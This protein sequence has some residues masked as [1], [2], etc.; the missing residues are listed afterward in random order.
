[1]TKLIA[2][3]LLQDTVHILTKLRNRL[4]KP[5]AFLPMGTFVASASHLRHVVETEPR[6]THN[7]T[8]TDL[9]NKDR[10]NFRA[11]TR[12]TSD[13]VLECVRK[14]PESDG[15]L[16]YLQ[17]MQDVMDSYLS[18]TLA[19]D[20]RV[21]LVWRA[22]FF[23]RRWRH[24]LQLEGHSV[25]D[26]FVSANAYVCV[27]VNAHCLVLAIRRLREEGTPE[28]FLPH[29]FSSQPCESAFRDARS[30]STTRATVINFSMQG[31]LQRGRRIELQGAIASQLGHEFAFLR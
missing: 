6:L 11:V 15:T 18:E 28:Y 14:V 12:M 4:L 3:L 9:N 21:F 29:L 17:I 16:A 27:E 2:F 5:D 7:L 1:M 24:W 23:L 10:M 26:S 30:Q 31:M 20:R 8:M 25:T 13:A 22:L 19:S